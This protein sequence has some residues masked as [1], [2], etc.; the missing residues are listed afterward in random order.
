MLLRTLTTCLALLMLAPAAATAQGVLDFEGDYPLA[1]DEVIL[2]VHIGVGAL[3][4]GGG[5]TTGTHVPISLSC[6][7]VEEGDAVWASIAE[8]VFVG[9][10]KLRLSEPQC[11]AFADNVTRGIAD[12]NNA[13]L[14]SLPV[15]STVEVVNAQNPIARLFRL[16][17]ARLTQERADGSTWPAMALLTNQPGPKNGEFFALR[18]G[19]RPVAGKS[20]AGCIAVA[21]GVVAGQIHRAERREDYTMDFDVTVDGELVCVAIG[22]EGGIVATI[23][24]ALGGQLS[25]PEAEF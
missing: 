12:L 21:A 4:P 14:D 2:D 25:T 23:G 1:C 19:L 16:F 15:S 7:R 22:P 10:R 3:G 8:P 17:S 6:D 9:C 5:G 20:G 18:V 13:V 24:V 11:R